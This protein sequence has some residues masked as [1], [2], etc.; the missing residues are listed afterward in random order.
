M[1]AH[2][3]TARHRYI[4]IIT[5]YTVHIT[6]LYMITYYT[7]SVFTYIILVYLRRENPNGI[8]SGEETQL[9]RV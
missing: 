3:D 4:N 5:L 9:I 7:H 1:Y 2:T 8:K 6:L